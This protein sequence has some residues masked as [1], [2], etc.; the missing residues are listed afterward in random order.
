MRAVAVT[1]ISSHA[2]R[3][4]AERY[5]ETLLANLGPN[6]VREV[7]CLEE[8][9]FAQRL[10]DLGHPTRVISTAADPASLVRSASKLRRVLRATRPEAVH[11]NGLKAALVSALAT[12]G[13]APPIIWVKHDFSWDGR[14]AHVVASRCALVVCVSQAVAGTFPPRL[15]PKIRV[16]R[17]G[18][19]PPSVD[20]ETGRSVLRQALQASPAARLIT[21]VGY[22]HPVKAQLELVEIIP[23]L[24]ERLP[25]TRFAFV[26]GEDT[27]VPEYALM[28]RD[29][30]RAL[31]I[32]EAA[33]FLGHRDDAPALVAG[34]DVLV[35]PA[36]PHGRTRGAEGGPLVVL[37]ALALGTPV[38]GYA[39]G[40][41]PE[42]VADCGV[43]A[44][45]GD[46][47]ALTDAILRVLTDDQL[48]E[49][50]SRCGR[51][52]FR[53]AFDLSSWVEALR[54]RYR[55]VTIR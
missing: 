29:R 1:F 33:T 48:Q 24:L 50:L 41:L 12:R 7:I 31:G 25:G 44:P 51:E 10:R 2:K 20:R 46:R 34:S 45:P 18:I 13:T 40:A 8:G 27:S 11:A 16:V 28:V 36:G 37:E 14:L 53:T 38:V 35:V 52:R 43:L 47:S 3:G 32:A 17:T 39:D 26:G 42:F 23:R 30:V 19:A 15:R 54:E 6:W 9:P 21:Q 55:E 22:L 4:G 49:R 5:L